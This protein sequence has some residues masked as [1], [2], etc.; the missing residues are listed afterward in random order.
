[1]AFSYAA[2]DI[3]YVQSQQATCN[4]TGNPSYAE[5]DIIWDSGDQYRFTPTYGGEVCGCVSVCE[6][7][8][9]TDLYY[10]Y[11]A[12]LTDQDKIRIIGEYEMAFNDF[13][14]LRDTCCGKKVNK[15]AGAAYA[16]TNIGKYNAELG[17]HIDAAEAYYRT[18]QYLEA[19]E[20]D[21]FEDYT[22][23]DTLL[24]AASFY[25]S[26]G[27]EYCEA[28]MDDE[29]HSMFNKARVIYYA[30]GMAEDHTEGLID[31]EE[32]GKYAKDETCSSAFILLF[33]LGGALFIKN[34]EFF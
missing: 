5:Y 25:R 4:P 29:A 23:A 31:D 30:E 18:A 17:N 1:M 21:G 15:W 6:V 10:P 3:D 28:G 11:D 12:Q 22:G 7:L 19:S 24:I 14:N 27:K 2:G 33:V 8:A 20:E 9:W 26:S 32:C 16:Q 34:N 13:K